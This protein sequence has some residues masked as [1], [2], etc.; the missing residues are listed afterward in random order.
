MAAPKKKPARKQADEVD[1]SLDMNPGGI[2]NIWYHKTLGDYSS[3]RERREAKLATATKYRC[4]P[5][6]DS[7]ETKAKKD[8][9]FC[10][11][12]ARGKCVHGSNCTFLHR[13]PTEEDERRV[14]L[15]VDAF[16]R[17]RHRTDR[18][19]MGGVG[20]FERNNKTLYIGGLKLRPGFDTEAE[21]K[22]QFGA[23]GEIDLINVIPSKSI[24]FV[25]YKL[26][27]CAEFAKE[28][29]GDQSIDG[30]EVLNVR[31]ANAD[32]NPIAQERDKIDTL[33]QAADAVQAK[34]PDLWQQEVALL[35]GQYPQTDP[36]YIAYQQYYGMD[37]AAYYQHY[38]S[39]HAEA[40]T[41]TDPTSA[42]G[43][44]KRKRDSEQES[45]YSDPDPLSA[46]KKQKGE[47]TPGAPVSQHTDSPAYPAYYPYYAYYPAYGYSE[48]PASNTESNSAT[49]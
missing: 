38:Y 10:L 11:Y 26:R 7:G 36:N 31:W 24:A 3:W 49:K 13:I 15:G 27:L 47:I 32:P 45:G 18:E 25:R 16:G 30:N 9:Q 37:P 42:D 40:D 43:S 14:G 17:E 8:A 21:I 19:D 6:R 23:F 33:V 4:D 22:R 46:S 1:K 12:F 29:M 39:Q 5:S 2:Y 20:S 35:Q 28:A 34:Y 48:M 41:A 44:K